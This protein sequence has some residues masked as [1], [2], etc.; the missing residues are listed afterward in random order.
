MVLKNTYRFLFFTCFFLLRLKS[1]AQYFEFVEN[2]GQWNSKVNFR[3][4]MKGGAVF[5][6]PG[7]YK[8]MLHNLDDLTQISEYMGG[9][10]LFQQDSLKKSAVNTSAIKKLIL[11]SHAYEVNFLGANSNAVAEPDKPLN[12]YNNYFIGNDSSKW[13]GHCRLFTAVNFKDLYK[14][15]DIRYYSDNG[16]L[17]YDLI[18]K[19]G[20]DI[21]TIAIKIDGAEK[22]YINKYGNLTIKTSVGEVYE[23]KP[24]CYQVSETGRNKIESKF[25]LK[26][27][28]LRFKI[29]NYNK[30]LALV[31]D[32][33][34]IFS[35]FV[36]SRSDSW[37]YSATYDNA[38]NLYAGGIDFG[39]GYPVS[40][41]AFQTVFGAGDNSEGTGAGYDISLIKFS[42]DG[43]QRIYATYL[44]GNGDEQPHSLVVDSRGSLII[45]GRTTSQ[46]FP[47]RSPDFGP[48][49]GFDII[50]A[51]L[52]PDG[53]QLSA[54]RKFGG[55]GSDGVNIQPKYAQEGAISIRRN[56]G[57]DARSEV[58]TDNANNI[59]L[60]SCTQ[61][62]NFPTTANAYKKG[63]GGGQDGVLIKASSDL[64]NIIG[65][66]YVGGNAEDAVFALA[67]GPTGEVYTVG[68]TIS[69]DLKP[70]SAN[71]NNQIC[72]NSFQ[73]GVCDGMLCIFDNTC[74]TLKSIC[75][76]GTSGNDLVYGVQ[77][78]KAG[79][80]YIMGTT[81]VAFPIIN[82]LFTSQ[83]DGKQF[84][85]KL[86][87][88]ISSV[89][90][91]TNFG[92]G[93]AA[94]DISPTA[95]LVDICEQVYV[96]GW[97]GNG[98]ALTGYPNAS[99]IGLKT[100]PNAI[101][102]TSD[103]SDFYFFVLEKD[104]TD[105]LWGSFFGTDAKGDPSVYGDHVD[106][107][108]SRFDRRGVIYQAICANCG[109]NGVF[110]VSPPDVWSPNNPAA[111]GSRCNEAAVK[112]AFEL[113]GVIASIRPSIN[114]VPRDSSG[115]IPLTVDFLDT[116]A[117]G[118]SYTWD[119]GDGSP[120][121]TTT[122]P[123][124]SHTY[125]NVGVY[126]VVLIS[127][128][129]S[130]CNVSDTTSINIKAKDNKAQLGFSALKRPP[131]GSTPF[132]YDFTNTSI[133]AIGLNFGANAFTWDWGDGS[134]R[135]NSNAINLSHS[136]I[137]EGVYNVSL[138]LNDTNFCN[139]PDSLILQLRIAKNLKAQFVTAPEGCTPY[140]AVFTN[141]TLGGQTFSWDFGDGNTST[142]TDPVHLYSL[143][144]NYDVKMKAF[145][146]ATCNPVDSAEFQITV[147]PGP[148]SA[149]SFDP[150]PP[151]QNIATNFTNLSSG[152]VK[153]FWDFGDGDTLQ[154]T[155]IKTPV[156]HLYNRTGTYKACLITTN[157][158]GCSADSCQFIDAI[159]SPSVDVPN[160]FTPNGDGINDIVR[161]RG[162]GVLKMNFRIFNRWGQLMFQATSLDQF[163]DGKFKGEL[164]AQDVYVYVLDIVFT[165]NT[166]FQ[167]K[168]DITL[169][170]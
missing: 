89:I 133:P 154:T 152:G 99:T 162:F 10:H 1:H 163:W 62:G 122:L 139:A 126:H 153:Y 92:K 103:G 18:V 69:T 79:A 100:T 73:G 38:G 128:D 42:S 125:N 70:T 164:Q 53:S 3:T 16:N 166:A 28:I 161:V 44:G 98:N 15:I 120:V 149:F 37:G 14:D 54:S 66:T 7:G 67:I 77:F 106:G 4:D 2:K 116:I 20:A 49:G 117:I 121:V 110:P 19:P 64:N 71:I 93:Q 83:Q 170:R 23:G 29:S 32:P 127:T 17:K 124:V 158:F 56:Y 57:D 43:R 82:S 111:T 33:T 30:N 144:G 157:E 141:T 97:G 86:S 75:Y 90:Y 47:V 104:A 105:Q 168:G 21:S 156:K 91:S 26:D 40:P 24:F 87:P 146:N 72:F 143:P 94:P 76:V 160:A 68:G 58:I 34:L 63:L 102:T 159:V 39:T 115:C 108:T 114:G 145:D 165:D 55:S 123:S 135:E 13:A 134:P 147:H 48:C 129:P 155:D 8:V 132:I 88:D 25:D 78:D 84:I 45:S 119:F 35:T 136:Y 50:I 81:T 9:H 74:N 109:K 12:T 27:N 85:S 113:S 142:L 107:G 96:S 101:L 60:A 11:H 61:S 118:T 138:T 150:N 65:S 46:N 41:G 140:S 151:V 52:S 5:L 22:L 59:Y 112:I 167:K 137:A 80:V 31:I 130:K 169:L 6:Q 51:K 36:G 95:F 148:E 131:C